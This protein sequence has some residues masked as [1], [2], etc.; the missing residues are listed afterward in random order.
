ME[1]EKLRAE[2]VRLDTENRS[3]R[4]AQERLKR[5]VGDRNMRNSRY[6]GE[7]RDLLKKLS[8]Q[9][10]LIEELGAEIE[11]LSSNRDEWSELLGSAAGKSERL[12]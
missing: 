6:R 4:R 9:G 10:A 11:R 8:D 7:I 1:I 5:A 2:I 3:L 12:L